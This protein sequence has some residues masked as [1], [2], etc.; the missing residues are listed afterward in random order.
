MTLAVIGLGSS[1]GDRSRNLRLAARLLCAAPEVRWVAGS[2]LWLTP[3]M[4]GVARGPF[5]NAA[6]SVETSLPPHALL[7]W[8]KAVESR[9]GR[10]PA[11]RWADRAI[12][13]DVLLYGAVVVRSETLTIPHAGLLERD[14]ALRPAQEVAP[15]LLHPVVGRALS[16]LP[17]PV[18]GMRAVGVLAPATLAR[19]GRLQYSFSQT[20]ASPGAA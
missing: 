19:R 8:C 2:R 10:R 13:L 15:S 14:F 17:V 12:D 9:V 4:G 3:P 20:A 11:R 5:L 7:S 16:L 1:L 6:L 18:G